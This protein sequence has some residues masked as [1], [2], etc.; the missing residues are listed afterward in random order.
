MANRKHKISC[1]VITYNEADRIAACLES[2]HNWVDQLIIMDSGSSDDTIAIAKRYTDEVYSTDWPGYGVQRNRALAK[3]K[4]DWV[5]YPDADEV[6]S[7]SLKTEIDTIL[8]TDEPAFNLV[9]IPW[10]TIMFGK[11]LH[12]GRYTA[13]QEKIFHKS[14]AKFKTPWDRA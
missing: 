12:Y 10:K 3:C 5:L 4:Y 13:I 14:A 7:D 1:F 8:N 2:V 6:I 11:A 9:K